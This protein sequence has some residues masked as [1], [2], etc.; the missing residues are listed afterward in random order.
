MASSNV[1]SEG[2]SSSACMIRSRTVGS[3]MLNSPVTAGRLKRRVGHRDP[4]RDAK[5]KQ[6]YERHDRKCS[7]P[8]QGFVLGP[9]IPGE[10]VVLSDQGSLNVLLG[11]LSD[12]RS[13]VLSCHRGN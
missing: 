5:T 6:K 1:P 7:G 9:Y 10:N 4:I 13:V 8:V 11:P 12:Y 2:R 3:G